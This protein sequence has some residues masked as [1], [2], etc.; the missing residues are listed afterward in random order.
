MNSK[1][2]QIAKCIMV[3]MALFLGNAWCSSAG[4]YNAIQDKDALAS[5][6][7]SAA[8]PTY[9]F[10]R[11]DFATG[12][13]PVS[14]VPADFNGDGKLDLAVTNGT[15]N[16]V[17]ILLGKPDGTFQEHID[18][19]TASGPSSLTVGDFDGDSKLDLGVVAGGGISILLGNGDGTFQ[20]HVDYATGSA[21][22]SVTAGDFNGDGKLDLAVAA[23]IGVSVLLGNGDGTFQTHVDYATGLGG[24]PPQDVFITSVIT[25][26]FNSDGKLDLAVA[27]AAPQ[28]N[29]MPGS[30]SIL[31][32]N[33]DGTFRAHVDTPVDSPFSLAAGD[34]NGGGKLDLATGDWTCFSE[35]SCGEGN[36]SILLGNGDGTFQP[37]VGYGAGR[38]GPRSVTTGDFNGDGKLDLAVGGFTCASSDFC[39]HGVSVLLGNGDGS[40][41]TAINYGTA[42]G[43]GPGFTA[44]DFNGD[45]KLDLAVVGP[46][47]SLGDMVSILPG[48]GDGT[49]PTHLEYL[50]GAITVAVTADDFNRDGKLDLAVANQTDNTVSILLGK[51]DGTFQTHTDYATGSGPSSLTVGDFND[52]GKPDIAV[53]NRTGNTVSI[54][55]GNGDGTFQNQVEY[56]TDSGPSSVT[57]GDFNGDG[58]LDLAVANYDA[59]T[60]SIL[61]G[62]GSGTFQTHT[63]YA[64][65]PNPG[66]VVTG[67]F[68]GDRKPDLAVADN[69][70]VSVL[71]GKGDGTFLTHVDYATGGAA[72]VIAADFNGDGKL[73]LAAAVSGVA[74][75]LGRADGTFQPPAG[76][77]T[78]LGFSS[79]M[80]TGD[81]NGDGKLDLAIGG[82]RLS[83]LPGKGDGTFTT[84]TDYDYDTGSVLLSLAAGDFNKDG[85]LDLAAA[86]I[87]LNSS[88]TPKASAVSV[89]LN[90]PVVALFPN[91]LSFGQ[92]PVGT[93]S[94]PETVLLSNPSPVQVQISGIT[95]NGADA[96]DFTET[97]TCGTKILPGDN[98]KISVTFTPTASGT[99]TAAVIISDSAL[100][101]QQVISLTGTSSASIPRVRLDPTSIRF[102]HQPVGTASAAQKL[103]LTN[104][105]SGLLEI[106]G[107]AIHGD[108]AET[109]TCGSTVPAGGTCAIS[110]TFTPTTTGVRTGSL[111]L[112]DNNNGVPGSMQTVTL[113]GTGTDFTIS[114]TP[115][116]QT[117]PS[118]HKAAYTITLMSVSG[119]TGSVSLA[120]S[121]GPPNSTCTLSPNS[122][123]LAGTSTAKGTVTL[124]PPMNVNHGTFTLTF[125]ASSDGRNH[126]TS[127]SLTVK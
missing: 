127:V 98:C 35:G 51:G 13:G 68:N 65:G 30:V 111:T 76:Y 33:G 77:S 89:L 110:I 49:F 112:T 59:S 103:T 60:V 101:R 42:F 5:T 95:V 46:G 67:D 40:L 37:A 80:S 26:D 71:L 63:D 91:V 39:G 14:A 96:A 86:V 90:V 22:S 88:G 55:L 32:G 58:K 109:N 27:N 124:L 92:E 72:I 114:A 9:L 82:N 113:S 106:S 45:S 21:P 125:T 56:A 15:D 31:L 122:V 74:I 69:A 116:A 117:I 57:V 8:D 41:Q 47:S 121:G 19:A 54:L 3:G 34:F 20:P 79:S 29:F 11:G 85:G 6:T 120:C 28:E 73:D 48:K 1:R 105:G 107:I 36:V 53:A 115:A 38:A 87:T 100:A 94:E 62:I 61:L 99:R 78:D 17:S 75:L 25:A 50:A 70:G 83:V 123:M 81:F 4:L 16:T 108:F 119:F 2:R 18:Y 64:T 102:G 97:N 12:T 104:T 7:S 118:G 44:G 93:S 24:L 52:D 126:N 43:S 10:G 84:G 66:S 23:G